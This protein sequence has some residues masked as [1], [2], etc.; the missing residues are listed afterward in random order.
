MNGIKKFFVFLFLFCWIPMSL[1]AESK[2]TVL[3][4]TSIDL[5]QDLAKAI[6]HEKKDLSEDD[7]WS[8]RVQALLM[9]YAYSMHHL[10]K[11]DMR[12][13]LLNEV[14]KYVGG[15]A[16]DEG[17]QRPK[18]LNKSFFAKKIPKQ[19]FEKPF[20]LNFLEEKGLGYSLQVEPEESQIDWLPLAVLSLFQETVDQAPPEVLRLLALST[21]AINK[22]YRDPNHQASDPKSLI[23]APAYALNLAIDILSKLTGKKL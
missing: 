9:F 20:V 10:K 23:E 3:L 4:T 7:F 6:H 15:V 21:G 2:E 8:Y 11:E 22:W 17:L 5:K 19:K 18:L 12:I 13:N 14:Q 1:L 16:T